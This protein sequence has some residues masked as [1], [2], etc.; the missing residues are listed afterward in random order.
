[1]NRAINPA[2][3]HSRLLRIRKYIHVLRKE[4]KRLLDELQMSLTPKVE[5]T[6]AEEALERE[7]KELVERG[8]LKKEE[9]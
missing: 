6:N 4:E 3:T 5:L 7:W 9:I 2:A 8:I 1:M